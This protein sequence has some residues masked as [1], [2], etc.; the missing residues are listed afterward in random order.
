MSK[1]KAIKTFPLP[2][3][4]RDVR[5]FL[6]LAGYYRSFKKDFAAISKTLTLLKT[7]DVIL[8]VECANL[9][10]R[11]KLLLFFFRGKVTYTTNN[12]IVKWISTTFRIICFIVSTKPY[13]TRESGD[14]WSDDLLTYREISLSIPGM[15]LW[16]LVRFKGLNNTCEAMTFI[17]RVKNKCNFQLIIRNFNQ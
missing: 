8:A 11:N 17:W 7:K 4:V 1:V 13:I 3:N 14:A 9:S 15:L 5:S 6:G 10:K 2:R 16:Y 12:C